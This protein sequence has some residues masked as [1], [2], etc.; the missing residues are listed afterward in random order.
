MSSKGK[1]KNELQRVV[2]LFNKVEVANNVPNGFKLL[3]KLATTIMK[4]TG[5]SVAI[6]C[7]SEVFGCEKVIY[8][9]HE[10]LIA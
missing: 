9:L 5:D 1:D 4:E 10:N 8:I 3:Y 2:A 6:P 7:D